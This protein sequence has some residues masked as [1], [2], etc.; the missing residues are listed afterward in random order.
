MVASSASK[1]CTWYTGTLERV[2]KGHADFGHAVAFKQRVSRNLLPALQSGERESSRARD[3]Q[4]GGRRRDVK[5]N[6][7]HHIPKFNL[8]I[9]TLENIMT[10]PFLR[11]R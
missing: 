7:K 6:T 5:E 2:G 3:H 8:A 9:K 4:P 10:V 1:L 11:T